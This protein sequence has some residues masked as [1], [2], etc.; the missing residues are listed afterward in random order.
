MSIQVILLDDEALITDLLSNFLQQDPAIEVKGTYN[1]GVAFLEAMQEATTLPDLFII[2]YRI[3]DTDGLEL[4]KHLRAL[5]IQTP[6]ILL[7]SHYNDS[8]IS[9]IVKTGFAAFLPKNMKPS[10]LIE[11]IHEV[12]NKGF[13]LLPA[14][15]EHLREQMQ[16]KNQPLTTD[17]K[18]ALTEREV[19]V[20]HLIAQQKTGKEI[21]D[22]LFISLKTVEGHKN[23]LF[24]KTG[25][26]NVVG[27]IVYAV[28]NKLISLDEISMY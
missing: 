4:L 1:F 27:L 2:D 5:D 26:K 20:L 14:Q 6:V 8:L 18:I 12:H 28:Q 17:L 16:V 25:A 7:S 19:E 15:F 21:A 11:V 9:F 23:S 13:Y 22:Q 24:L 3:G 10:I